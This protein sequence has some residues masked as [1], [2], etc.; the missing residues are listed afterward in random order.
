MLPKGDMVFKIDVYFETFIASGTGSKIKEAK[1]AAADRALRLLYKDSSSNREPQYQSVNCPQPCIET[2]TTDAWSS[3][4]EEDGND[5]ESSTGTNTFEVDRYVPQPSGSLCPVSLG[6]DG[7]PDMSGSTSSSVLLDG[8]NPVSA[9]MELAQ[10]GGNIG[11]FEEETKSGPPHCPSF[12][13]RAYIGNTKLAK[14]IGSTKKAAKRKA[15]EASLNFIQPK[16]L[17]ELTYVDAPTALS[18]TSIDKNAGVCPPGA[19]PISMLNEYA[20]KHGLELRYRYIDTS[21]PDHERTFTYEAVVGSTGYQ[22]ASAGSIKEAKRE[23]CR[24]ALRSLKRHKLYNYQSGLSTFTTK[25]PLTF[26]DEIAKLCHEKF[27]A[28]VGDISENLAGRKVIAGVVMESK[29][30]STFEVISLASG[31]R[32]IRGDSL[33]TDGQVLVDSHAEILAARGMKRFLYH[34]I[35]QLIKGQPSPVLQRHGNE[36]IEL[37]SGVE[38]HLYISTAPCGDGAVFT[39]SSGMSV[40]ADVHHKPTFDDNKQGLLRS[41]IEQGEGQIPTKD[42]QSNC[43]YQGMDAV[44]NGERLRVMSCSD[45]ICKWNLLGVQGALLANL[46]KPVYLS[47]I[48]L[49]N[50]YNH[51]HM[52]RAM[53]CRLEKT[54]VVENLPFGYKL[55]HPL[56]GG[57]SHKKTPQRSVGKSTAY[58]INWNRADD[59]HEITDGTTG[60][61]HNIGLTRMQGLIKRTSRLC[62]KDML[63]SYKEICTEVGIGILVK[64]EYLATKKASTQYQSCKKILYTTLHNQGYGTWIRIPKECQE[65]PTS[66]LPSLRNVRPSLFSQ[67]FGEPRYF[68]EEWCMTI[69]NNC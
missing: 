37:V 47:S 28:V 57:V 68:E 26:H 18:P 34:H 23:A 22:G 65:F 10:A 20:Q 4:P 59:C 41:K 62:K 32:F 24:N 43:T 19:D 55:N 17:K 46:M 61:L 40:D 16:R 35:K 2:E 63:K 52:A 25:E 69:A 48:T 13:M 29:I 15:A 45:K 31:N 14:G 33:T 9:F 27:D 42:R 1:E 51:G 60:F 11:R 54:Q 38:F 56:L 67:L 7:Q 58:S 8:K 30:N 5:S 21:G 50:L 44:R 6:W 49:G 39:P 66:S 64:D 12:E 3:E 53:C 36:K